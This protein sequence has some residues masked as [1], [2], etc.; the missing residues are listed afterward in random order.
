MRNYKQIEYFR[1]L[2]KSL[3]LLEAKHPEEVFKSHLEDKK[4]ESK[5][6]ES[7]KINMA[8]SIASSFI[9]AGFGT[10]KLLSKNDSDWIYKNK[11]EGLTCLLAGL[12]MVN[13]WDYLEGPGKLFEYA[14][15][16]EKDVY[17]RAGRNI[18]L[19]ISLS[20]IHD[21]NDIAVA[22]LLEELKDKNLS[23]IMNYLK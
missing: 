17:K 15:N 8:Y 22:V 2:G 21:D 1:F 11:E 10:E 23:K 3:E 19:G 6:L 9:N 14:G 20:T 13:I 7:Y 4:G 18:G 5:K 12:G 16:K